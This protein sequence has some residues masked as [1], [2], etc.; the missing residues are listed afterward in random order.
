V[1][2]AVSHRARPPSQDH[3]RCRLELLGEPIV[4]INLRRL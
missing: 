3:E 4:T 2:K 1:K